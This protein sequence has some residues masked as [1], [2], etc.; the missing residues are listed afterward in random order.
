MAINDSGTILV[1]GGTE[2]V[3]ILYCN[4]FVIQLFIRL[5]LQNITD[6]HLITFPLFRLYVF[7]ILDLVLRP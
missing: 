6:K 7:G 3:S 5:S 2:K 1:S 4:F